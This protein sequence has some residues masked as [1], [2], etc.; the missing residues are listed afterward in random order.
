[1]S[2]QRIR[3]TSVQMQ[4]QADTGLSAEGLNLAEGRVMLNRRVAS[5]AALIVVRGRLKVGVIDEDELLAPGDGVLLP[6]GTVYSLQALED[7]VAVLFAMPAGNENGASSEP[8]A[9]E[10]DPDDAERNDTDTDADA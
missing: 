6:G 2:L 8:D 9:A 4:D 10:P 1:M 7:S 3:A 5:P